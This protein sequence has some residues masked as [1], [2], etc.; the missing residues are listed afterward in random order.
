[1]REVG[2]DLS[3]TF[4]FFFPF[5]GILGA[6]FLRNESLLNFSRSNR[7][8]RSDALARDLSVGRYIGLR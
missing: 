1:M 2:D 6:Q 3:R 4:F 5:R 8:F 7:S